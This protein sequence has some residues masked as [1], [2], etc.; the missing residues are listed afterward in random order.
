M[1]REVI[2]LTTIATAYI[3][4]P[5]TNP[6]LNIHST[7][8]YVPHDSFNNG[9]ACP[10]M[11]ARRDD[12]GP[13][14][15][16]TSQSSSNDMLPASSPI[17]PLSFSPQIQKINKPQSPVEGS[18]M[19]PSSRPE[20]QVG[21][22]ADRADDSLVDRMVKKL[23]SLY[24]LTRKKYTIMYK[25]YRPFYPKTPD[26]E[27]ARLKDR[28]LYGHL[29]GKYS[30][31]VFSGEQVAKFW[32]FDVDSLSP[33]E[34]HRVVDGIV[35]F[36][37][38]REKVYVSFSG[39]KGYHVEVF[40]DDIVFVDWLYTAYD[41]VCSRKGLNRGKVEFRP[42]PT[43]SIK[44]PLGKHQETGNWC[45]F[46]DPESLAPIES[47]EYL[48]GVAQVSARAFDQL[49]REKG[50]TILPVR[51]RA[52]G[53]G[54]VGSR[55]SGSSD[56]ASPTAAGLLDEEDV[57]A[58]RLAAEEVVARNP[59]MLFT[60]GVPDLNEQN[61]G[62]H[63]LMIQIAMR[64]RYR[65]MSY[66]ECVEQLVAW[67]FR[68]MELGKGLI[69]STENGVMYDID[70]VAGWAY[71]KE[72]DKS[73]YQP[74]S[75]DKEKD[76]GQT[77]MPTSSG[78]SYQRQKGNGGIPFDRYDVKIL[79]A[80]RNAERRKLMFLILLYFKRHGVCGLSFEKMI[81][82]TGLTHNTVFSGIKSLCEGGWIEKTVGKVQKTK[83]GDFLRANNKYKISDGAYE[84]AR[85]G[86]TKSNIKV[87]GK[88]RTEAD[89]L[90]GKLIRDFYEMKDVKLPLDH[91]EF[92]RR[93]KELWRAFVPVGLQDQ[94]L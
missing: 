76:V 43:E 72:I 65:N 62:R 66:N 1:Y 3:P 46:C 51:R 20:W 83:E 38:P 60:D 28:T 79:A 85:L 37:I 8:S 19:L 44:L 87:S 61:S 74:G 91:E 9:V 84:W 78:C 88:K 21:L 57:F 94:Y 29:T 22:E 89:Y 17:V 41:W 56:A 71:S 24:V 25:G 82:V 11:D 73:G 34:I 59:K 27:Y 13:L 47:R 93:Y 55:G 32:C 63:K 39:R 86:F 35:E 68:Q 6:N 30:V 5:N 50:L 33:D 15:L 54:N 92:G 64:C 40:F 58:P 48:F 12:V 26:G 14:L 80:Q 16:S 69:E 7:D 52:V 2:R 23:N 81:R 70:R 31:G 67:Y 49:V 90:A 45:W 18:D 77:D 4:N 75:K 36:G 42:S 53:G 10:A